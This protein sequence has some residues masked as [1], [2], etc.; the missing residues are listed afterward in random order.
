MPS[1]RRE[2]EPVQRRGSVRADGRHMLRRLVTLV[3]HQPV[4]RVERVPLAHHLVPVNLGDD[5][6]GGDG[7][8]ALISL[9][10][11]L[12]GQRE[13]QRNSVHQHEIGRGNELL[14]G[15]LHGQ[16][17]RLID[18]DPVDGRGIHGGYRPGHG[19]LANPR[20]QHLT[21][22]RIDLFAVVETADGNIGREN[23]CPGDH[24]A[25]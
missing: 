23:D 12:L 1:H 3:I 14:D 9:N 18:I 24:G 11:R 5:G 6:S 8:T 7:M 2:T 4:I 25:E 15:G 19:P 17:G 13:V 22:F 21:A 20:S 10:D 16:T